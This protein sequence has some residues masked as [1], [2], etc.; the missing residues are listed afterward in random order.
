MLRYFPQFLDHQ[1][2]E[3]FYVA[4]K[5]LNSLGS[6]SIYRFMIYA[7]A[8]LLVTVYPATLRCFASAP[9]ASAQSTPMETT[10]I[11]MNINGKT[12][13]DM[14]AIQWPDG[15]YSLPLKYL[16]ELLDVSVYQTY[17]DQALTFVS[18]ASSETVRVAPNSQQITMGESII[19][20][21]AH[22]PVFMAQGILTDNDIFVSQA[23]VEKF[24]DIQTEFN[25]QK[26]VLNISVSRPLKVLL[27]MTAEADDSSGKR[28]DFED[29]TP[30][31]LPEEHPRKLENITL[32]L[33]SNHTR[34]L[35]QSA[36][37]DGRSG[38]ESILLSGTTLGTTLKG[39]LFGGRY[40]FTPRWMFQNGEF[41]V[42]SMEGTLNWRTN[43]HTVT[44]GTVRTGLSALVA[45]NVDLLG[46]QFATHNA[47]TP[48]V[49][50][51]GVRKFRGKAAPKGI[52]HL[53]IN[54]NE[55]VIQ[56]PKEGEYQFEEVTLKPETLNEIRITQADDAG[57]ET[58]LQAENIP[59]FLANLRAGERAYSAFA[60]RVLPQFRIV[61]LNYGN[62]GD[63]YRETGLF[64]PQS[65]KFMA[66]ARYFEGINDRLTLGFS[67][68]GD[69]IVGESKTSRLS[70][71]LSQLQ[72]P[73]LYNVYSYRRDP[74]LVSGVNGGV[75][76]NYRIDSNW[77]T[78]LDMGVSQINPAEDIF[79]NQ[80][81][82]LDWAGEASVRHVGDRRMD[83]I[84]LFHYGPQ[85]YTP[86]GNAYSD[87]YDRRGI[88]YEG[89]GQFWG[90]GY[91][92]L[93][94]RYQ[95]NLGGLLEGGIISGERFQGSLSRNLGRFGSINFYTYGMQGKNESQEI[96]RIT[97]QLN[98]SFR[99]PHQI[100][101]RL[102]IM[103]TTDRQIFS[104][105]DPT[106]LLSLYE[107]TDK[108][109]Y[110]NSDLNF[111]V[112]KYA[113]VQLGSN[114]S[115]ELA[116]VNCQL[117]FRLG[118][119][120]FSPLFQTSLWGTQTMTNM[121]LGL[122]YNWANG[123]RIGMRYTYNAMSFRSFG[124]AGDNGRMMHQFQFDFN[125]MLAM[126]GHRP[127]SVGMRG[128]STGIIE[129]RV[130]LDRNRNGLREP[131]EPD[132]PNVPLLYDQKNEIKTDASGKF[133][134]T[135]LS[136]GSHVIRYDLNQLPLTQSP[137]TPKLKAKIEPGK[138][139]RI[140]MGLIMTPGNASG[141]II[142]KDGDGKELNAVD[143]VI[144]LRDAST[145]EE[146]QFTYADKNG[147]F[148]L[149]DIPPGDYLVSIDEKHIQEKR[150]K[151]LNT[152]YPVSVPMQDDFY[153]KND[154]DFNIIQLM[155][156]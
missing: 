87:L 30:E 133:A 100:S 49:Q 58:L 43:R 37:L 146:I 102:G 143:T 39:Q 66:G 64:I 71:F 109:T 19:E 141:K 78:S 59:Y 155:R 75:T 55:T 67:V 91:N 14:E 129:G 27:R 51:L 44:T 9:K 25:P 34:T 82:S 11:S 65:N 8:C 38:N 86:S 84:S 74:N 117:N 107:Q 151:V 63:Q 50:P 40:E 53:K 20:N 32:N 24:F 120:Q 33:N 144:I 77:G 83:T 111:P 31:V 28:E 105:T 5:V 46:V 90:I 2:R 17:E 101:G 104:P 89:S 135:N 128:L 99:L 118:N 13:V 85:Y 130:F 76:L 124:G 79:Y 88:A 153:D 152:P 52:V 3:S 113:N 4:K 18:P 45:T 62:S 7:L 80:G 12:T 97:R 35:S 136:R 26:Q 132:I 137:T 119:F 10:F 145:K 47:V 36:S 140:A 150:L 94:E 6:L 114:L 41:G 48:Q 98:W 112:T 73:G 123:K 154:L 116:L 56:K 29:N 121:G 42:Q 142:M 126:I 127:V 16:G 149:S 57:Q 21:P 81:Q 92:M 134:L 138:H 22:G 61:G 69:R 23:L 106:R 156:K 54:G 96:N 15:S 139:T 1:L 95:M 131:G 108:R 148:S 103:E 60:G 110:L 70:A 93:L 68:A 147:Q 125:D 115:R 72:S 122:Y